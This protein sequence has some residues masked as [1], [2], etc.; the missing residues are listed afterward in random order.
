V[1]P[2]SRR[3]QALREHK[4]RA[5]RKFPGRRHSVAG[6][7]IDGFVRAGFTLKKLWSD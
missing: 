2:A 6:F 1:H 3:K 4:F 7:T 5:S